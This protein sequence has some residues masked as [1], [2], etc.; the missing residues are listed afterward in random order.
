M[1]RKGGRMKDYSVKNIREDFKKQGIFYTPPELARYI[2]SLVD[3]EYSNVYDPTCGAGNLLAEFE[4]HIPKYGQDVMAEAV[5]WARAN[6]PNFT[7]AI[8]DTLKEPAFMDM[9]FD[10]IVANPPFSIAWEE[11]SDERFEAAPCLPPKSKADY[12]FILHIIHM[13]SDN[14]TAIVMEFP[15]ILYRKAR[16]GKIRKWLIEQNYIEKVIAIPGKKF[17]DTAI[18]T[19]VL[20]LKK[21]R[22]KDS[23][24][25]EDIELGFSRDVSLGEIAD[26]KYSLN[27]STYVQK[28]EEKKEI[29]SIA[30]EYRIRDL[31]I[32]D[33]RK[34]L[35]WHKF[36]ATMEEIEIESLYRRIREIVGAAERGRG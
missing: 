4:E 19:C 17:T 30:L 14:G 3:V 32:E 22:T 8:G 31:F 27:V 25:F 16:E 2:K 36:V 21:N 28:E 26:N 33:I 1:R 15:G 12:A 13:L 9:K 24:I 23:I 5:E 7:G 11:K 20:M 6:I 35:E 18:A 10:L 34:K 29:D